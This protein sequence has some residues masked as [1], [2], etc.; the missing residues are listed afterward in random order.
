MI[1]KGLI[2]TLL[3]AVFGLIGFVIWQN[4]QIEQSALKAISSEPEQKSSIIRSSTHFLYGVVMSIGE[5]Y[6]FKANT[7]GVSLGALEKGGSF[8]PLDSRPGLALIVKNVRDTQFISTQ[9]PRGN[10]SYLQTIDVNGKVTDVAEGDSGFIRG[11]TFSPDGN[12]IMYL[13]SIQQYHSNPG[14]FTYDQDIYIMNVDG[15]AKE[16]LA[17][18]IAKDLSHKNSELFMLV[19]WAKG[20]TLYFVTG[21]DAQAGRQFS[22]LW[23]FDIA[24]KKMMKT[25][26]SGEIFAQPQ[27]SPDGTKIAYTPYDSTSEVQDWVATKP[28]SIKLLDLLTNNKTILRSNP[29]IA[30][31]LNSWSPDGTYLLYKNEN[32]HWARLNIATGFF[33]EFGFEG[34]V[35]GWVTN[36]KLVYLV[37][38]END[39]STSVDNKNYLR[40]ASFGGDEAKTVDTGGVGIWLF[41]A[42]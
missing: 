35:Q 36:D 8:M 28:Y 22:G 13:A 42:L 29:S 7:D 14:Y 34:Q 26:S 4:L 20:D 41:G 6:L 33:E 27:M 19:G 38:E 40:L 11:A 24:T 10:H 15:S 32:E 18:D 31:W 23:S 17:D 12:K 1:N 30:Y 2:I 3:I 37:E 25:D 16:M 5:Q 9:N 39:P 21:N